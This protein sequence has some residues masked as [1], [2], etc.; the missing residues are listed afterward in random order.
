VAPVTVTDAAE[1][2]R[3]SMNEEQLLIRVTDE[4][5]N[6]G[7]RWT[8]I[9]RS[10]RGVTMGHVGFPDLIAIRGTRILV[11]ELKSE[12]G[13]P[14]PGQR[15]WIVAFWGAGAE[16]MFLRPSDLTALLETLR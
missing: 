8:H 2:L 1:V 9:R 11:L 13:K 4:L 7:F 15:E 10:D 14:R 5:T 12:T 6:A 16:A 3:R